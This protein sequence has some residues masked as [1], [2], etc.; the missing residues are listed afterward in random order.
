[1]N[2]DIKKQKAAAGYATAAFLNYL[3]YIYSSSCLTDFW[4]MNRLLFSNDHKTSAK[5]F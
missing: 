2:N 3:S 1:M 5:F 4:E